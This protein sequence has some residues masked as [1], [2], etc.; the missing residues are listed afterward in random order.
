MCT[1]G[2]KLVRRSRMCRT[3]SIFCCEHVT[4]I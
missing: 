4:S 3:W 1:Q 2:Y